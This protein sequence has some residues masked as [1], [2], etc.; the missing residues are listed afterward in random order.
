MKKLL[1]FLLLP[2][3]SF[4]QQ[5]T[6]LDTLSFKHRISSESVVY[7][8]STILSKRLG[9]INRNA[10]VS[11]LGYDDKFW[12]VSHHRIQGFIHLSEIKIPENLIPFFER[13]E[14]KKKLAALKK[15]RE[16]DSL[17]QVERL[18]YRK[19]CF[20]EINEVNGFDKVKRIYTKEALIA[21][22]TDSEYTRISCQLRNN[23]G[24]KSV[25]I[26]L[27]RDLGCASSLKG[28]KSSVRIT[29]KNGSVIS[30][31]HYGQIECGNFKII[32]RLTGA[33]MAKLKRSPIKQIRFSG[34]RE[35]KT[36]SY[37][38]NPT[39]FMDKIQCIQ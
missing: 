34:T 28:Q 1:L 33:E 15:E 26:S 19:K 17:R 30:F 2:V 22:G 11:V 38:S 7:E 31:F 18:E 20:Y 8:S 13:E 39:F 27:N 35:K 32:G 10:L 23:N 4:S 12:F 36:V 9:T 25:L 37:I 21:D 24:A 3:I 6:D 5:Y 16:R 14:E 29:L